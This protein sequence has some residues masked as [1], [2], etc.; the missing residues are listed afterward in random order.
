M[1]GALKV[2]FSQGRQY[3]IDPRRAVPAGFRGRPL[4]DESACETSC[5]LCADVCPTSAVSLS[6]VR[7]DLGRC[8]FCNECALI[9]PEKKI[10]FTP[11]TRMAATT[12]DAL[13]IT[14]KDREPAPAAVSTALQALFGRSLKLRSVS[15]GGCNGC[16]LELNA[17]ANVNFDFGRY[18]IDWVASPRHADGLVLSGPLTVN[19]AD[20]I[21][22][23]YAGMPDPKFVISFG[24]CAISGGP[25]AQSPAVDRRFIERFAPSLYVPG[26]PP[27]PLTFLHGLL[28]LLGIDVEGPAVP[29]AAPSQWAPES[30]G[31]RR[32]AAER[33]A[34]AVGCD[35][36]KQDARE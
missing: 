8:I 9:C 15:A 10:V 27:H 16:E 24:A 5:R 19:M 29:A 7:I 14:A 17:M 30:V 33:L 6:P 28:D 13:V 11:E 36:G 31:A 20:A 3:I 34:R 35:L 25:F 23:A 26:C 32:D 2:R 22:L 1:F 12:P 4:I 21:E 18:G